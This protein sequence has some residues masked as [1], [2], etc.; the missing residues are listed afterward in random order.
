MKSQSIKG[1][2]YFVYENE[3]EFFGDY[4]D[5]NKEILVN[6]RHGEEGDWVRADDGGIVQLLKVVHKMPHKKDTPNYRFAN[7]YVRTVVGTFANREQTLMDTDFDKHENRYTFGGKNPTRLQDRETNTARDHMFITKVIQGKDPED[8]VKEVYRTN[9]PKRASNTAEILLKQERIMKEIRKGVLDLADE[10]G[11]TDE[12]IIDRLMA[13]ERRASTSDETL[14]VALGSLKEMI[15]IKQM[16]TT[17]KETKQIG[18]IAH[19]D[20]TLLDNLERPKLK[21]ASVGQ[22]KEREVSESDN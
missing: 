17:V 8:A 4:P 12:Y 18:L 1:I 5:G 9:N 11:M 15:K 3:D 13:L 19:I 16:A 20:Q 6:W 7:G 10:K 14:N 21:E 22:T 2:E